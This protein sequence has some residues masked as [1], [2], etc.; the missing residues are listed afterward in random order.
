MSGHSKWATIK[1]KKGELDAKKG[2]VFTKLSR[3]ITTAARLGGG[4]PGSNP[5][6]RLAMV[7]ARAARMPADTIERARKKG[8]GALEGPPVEE[9]SYEGYGP[10][11]VAMLVQA[12]TDNRNRTSA[13][14]RA[15]FTKAGGNLGTSGSVA[16]LFRKRGRVAVAA[17]SLGEEAAMELALAAGADDV[18]VDGDQVLIDCDPA[19]FG[20]LLDSLEGREIVPDSAAVEQV[21]ETEIRLDGPEAQAVSRLIERLEEL[22]DVQ[23]VHA[24]M[25]IDGDQPPRAG[26]A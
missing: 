7:S 25:S 19:Q 11:G 26:G 4:D 16:W 12:Q 1:R 5:R 3:E 24:N 18:R 15:A 6:L 22:D 14:V 23:E 13:D 2:K 9:V 20:A 8:T 21:A 17:A 10:H